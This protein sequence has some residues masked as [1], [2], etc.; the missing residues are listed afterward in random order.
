MFYFTNYR[1]I[2]N[3]AAKEVE[4]DRT[5]EEEMLEKRKFWRSQLKDIALKLGFHVLSTDELEDITVAF[6]YLE[7]SRVSLENVAKDLFDI[8]YSWGDFSSDEYDESDYDEYE[9]DE[10]IYEDVYDEDVFD[11]DFDEYHDEEPCN[12]EV[13][14]NY[15]HMGESLHSDTF[16]VSE[17]KPEDMVHQELMPRLA[18]RMETFKILSTRLITKFESSDEHIESVQF[19]RSKLETIERSENVAIEAREILRDMYDK[20]GDWNEDL[21]IIATMTLFKSNVGAAD[22]Y[23]VLHA[24]LPEFLSGIDE[25]QECPPQSI[26]RV[27]DKQ[28]VTFPMK[29]LIE[30]IDERCKSRTLKLYS[31]DVGD[32]EV[33]LPIHIDDGY[34]N[35]FD[36]VNRA[37]NDPVVDLFMPLFD[38]ILNKPRSSSLRDEIAELETK[39]R[40]L[41]SEKE[42]LE[43]SQTETP[44]MFS[45][46]GGLCLE[47]ESGEY[48]YNICPGGKASQNKKNSSS[49]SSGTSLGVNNYGI[50]KDEKTNSLI[51]K[52]TGG[53]KCWNGPNRS[54]AVYI[55]CGSSHA[56]LTATEPETCVYEFTM[57]STIACDDDF[58]KIHDLEIPS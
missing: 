15:A 3:Y 30:A 49:S 4:L 40:G 29:D 57:Q 54:A 43:R 24:S 23:K 37:T 50:E 47:L 14:E 34:L 36:F 8:T 25:G 45:F 48:R 12:D 55:T 27:S 38:N 5:L 9:Y 18:S 16:S 52:F 46:H 22:L 17:E 20:V 35:Y 53:L 7:A 39:V 42:S 31:S 6:C 19:L 11:E 51:L 44:E 13:D 33:E 2:H 28:Y 10:N 32:I 21:M 56:I 1:F 58:A 26:T 41:K